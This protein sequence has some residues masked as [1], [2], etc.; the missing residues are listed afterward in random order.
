ME[1]V[2]VDLANPLAAQAK[3]VSDLLAAVAFE[4]NREKDLLGP[5]IEHPSSEV[6]QF[7]RVFQLY[8]L[9]LWIK[10][11]AGKYFKER[12]FRLTAWAFPFSIA[13]NH[14]KF[15]PMVRAAKPLPEALSASVA[16]LPAIV[17]AKPS[18]VPV[19]R[20]GGYWRSARSASESMSSALN[21]VPSRIRSRRSALMNPPVSARGRGLGLRGK[22]VFWILAYMMSRMVSSRSLRAR[23]GWRDSD[24]REVDVIA[25]LRV[26]KNVQSESECQGFSL[27]RA[28]ATYRETSCSGETID[29]VRPKI[30]PAPPEAPPYEGPGLNARGRSSGTRRGS[31][32]GSALIASAAPEVKHS[33]L[34]SELAPQAKAGGRNFR[35]SRKSR[36]TGVTTIKGEDR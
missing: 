15:G 21:P 19:R 2:L 9:G 20:S 16:L 5:V 1:D 7:H 18:Q 27:R 22:R 32:S 29:Q 30:D 24:F 12:R 17:T 28:I 34:M 26:G 14:T 13:R 36:G 10:T 35:Q 6:A 4:V 3:P 11:A 33:F 8:V 25:N 31:R 23:S